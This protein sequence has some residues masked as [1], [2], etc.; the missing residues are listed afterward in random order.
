MSQKYQEKDWLSEERLVGIRYYLVFS[1]VKLS[2]PAFQRF[3]HQGT[4][5]TGSPV[6]FALEK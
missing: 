6:L 3:L 5:N 4:A 2:I 1:K